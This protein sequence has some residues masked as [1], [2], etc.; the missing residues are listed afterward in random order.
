MLETQFQQCVY[1]KSLSLSS[2][3]VTIHK[4]TG[5]QWSARDIDIS[6][7]ANYRYRYIKHM[8]F[9]PIHISDHGDIDATVSGATFDVRMEMGIDSTR[10]PSV[11]SASCHSYID[12]VNVH[13]SG[14]GLGPTILNLLSSPIESYFKNVLRSTLCDALKKVVDEDLEKSLHRA[15]ITSKIGSKFVLDYGLQAPPVFNTRSMETFH[16]GIIY[17][18][19]KTEPLPFSPSPFPPATSTNKMVY[20]WVSGYVFHSLTYK[21]QMNDILKKTLT[22]DDFANGI[23]GFL[24][25]SCKFGSMC[26]GKFLPQLQHQFPHQVVEVELKSRKAPNIVLVNGELHL[27]MN[28][29]MALYV[30]PPTAPERQYLFT[31]DVDMASSIKVRY[32]A[33]Y[34]HSKL[35]KMNFNICISNSTLHPLYE[36]ALNF[37]MQNIVKHYMQPELDDQGAKGLPLL[38]SDDIKLINTDLTLTQDAIIIGT[39]LEVIDI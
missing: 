38:K 39:D 24:N 4:D 18:K 13:F 3:S 14:G 34:L 5:I 37:I 22:N 21:A 1:V 7:S 11:R 9:I 10:R 6:V 31:M 2:S 33:G 23:G 20:A 27:I 15:R 35:G 30:K 25:T 8:A 29:S 17:W 19:N 28:G 16:K 32:S 12:R 36:H 26:V